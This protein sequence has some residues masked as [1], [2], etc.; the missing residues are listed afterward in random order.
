MS[1]LEHSEA[2]VKKTV[3]IRIE[4]ISPDQ[5]LVQ[6]VTGD[7]YIKGS[8]YYYRYP[9]PDPTMGPTTTTVKVKYHEGNL[10]LNEQEKLH[11]HRLPPAQITVIRHGTLESEQI[12]TEHE[13]EW[14]FYHMTSGKLV[15]QTRTLR[16]EANLDDNGVGTLSWVYD[17]NVSNEE[18]GQFELKLNIQEEQTK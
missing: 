8:T 3:N 14:G 12:F 18:V 2:N 5:T 7:L 16:I 6:S 17:L 10:P 1:D 9:E 4:S 11:H 15:L 13:T